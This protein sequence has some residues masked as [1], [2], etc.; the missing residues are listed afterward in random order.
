MPVSLEQAKPRENESFKWPSPCLYNV[1]PHAHS[2]FPSL[3]LSSSPPLRGTKSIHTAGL[4]WKWQLRTEG[5]ER[6]LGWW[7][8][9]WRK[10]RKPTTATI[11]RRPTH[12][13]PDPSTQRQESLDAGC[14]NLHHPAPLDSCLLTWLCEDLDSLLHSNLNQSSRSQTFF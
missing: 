13:K 12:H 2:S 10:E 11:Q 9:W 1:K 7:W 14:W 5:S 3:H 6:S 8:W 4:L